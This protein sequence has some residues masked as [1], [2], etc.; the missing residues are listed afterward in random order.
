LVKPAVHD[1]AVGEQFCECLFCLGLL[2]KLITTHIVCYTLYLKLAVGR[3]ELPLK[4][5]RA[6]STLHVMRCYV[7][8]KNCYTW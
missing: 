4:V 2:H 1:E 5:F 6:R 7:W 8:L 3:L